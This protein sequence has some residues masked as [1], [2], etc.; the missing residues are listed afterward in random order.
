MGFKVK[1]KV[2]IVTGSARGIGEEIAQRLLNQGAKVCISDVNDDE[3]QSANNYC[4]CKE[5][6][7]IMR[8][9]FHSLLRFVFLTL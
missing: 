6:L 9:Y 1:D 3:W 7:I 5:I 2:C 4:I 8:C